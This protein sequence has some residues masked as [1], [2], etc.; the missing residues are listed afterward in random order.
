MPRDKTKKLGVVLLVVFLLSGLL[1]PL[2]AAAQGSTVTMTA[3]PYLGGHVKYGEW[4]ALRVTLHNDGG[5]LAA[6]VRAEVEGSTG[7]VLYAVPVQLPAGARKEVTVYV[8]PSSFARS[9]KVRLLDGD[10]VLAESSVPISTYPQRDYLIGAVA[11]DAGALVLLKGLT[12]SARDRTVLVPLALADLPERAEAL[13]SLDCLLLSGVDTTGMT[14]AQGKALDTWLRAGGRLLLGGGAGAD[15]TLAGLPESLQVQPG[16]IEELPLLDALAAFAGEPIR[17]P[18]PFVAAW[19]A[20]FGGRA[21]IRQGEQPLLVQRAVGEGW[22]SYLAL[23]PA[24]SP[25]DAWAGVLPFWQ[26]LLE[27]GSALPTN[28]PVDIPLRAIEAEMMGYALQ[29]VPAVQPPSIIWLAVLLGAYIVLVG[30]VN[31]FLLRRLRRLAWAWVTIPLLTLVFS[32]GGIA[33]G[34]QMRGNDVLISQISILPVSRGGGPI[35][36]RSY[37]GV[38]S[39]TSGRYNLR[40]D[41]EALVSPIGLDPWMWSGP[42]PAVYSPLYVLEGSPTRVGGLDIS[43][44]AMRSFQAE[45]VVNVEAFGFEVDLDSVGDQAR[46]TLRNGLDR[47]LEDVLL[48]SGARYARLGDLDPGEERAFEVDLQRFEGYYPGVLWDQSFDAQTMPSARSMRRTAVLEA[49]FQRYETVTTGLFVLA[50]T[51]L[52]PVSVHID[53]VRETHEQTTL[54]ISRPALPVVDGRVNLPLGYLSAQMTESAGDTGFCGP[55]QFYVGRGQITLDYLLP[56]D[57]GDLV[58]ESMTVQVTSA[59]GFPLEIPAVRLYDW[60]RAE[61]VELTGLKVAT[62]YQI[63]DPR[64]YVDGAGGM[65]RL[66][67]EGEREGFCFRFELSLGGRLEEGP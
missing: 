10:V 12:L 33:L 43:Q 17:V 42:S 54:L 23:D 56:A 48:F 6:E 3:A 67:A 24:G 1:L 35:L 9:I 25:F 7:Q 66:Q 47:P 40:L 49:L 15:R 8:L 22:L 58:V 41:G 45:T 29:N 27:P 20:E 39:P 62:P 36:A 44:W 38:F 26:R 14:A 32:V 60:T 5:D 57:L 55:T 4:L 52:D 13:R 59:D 30:P 21:L 65:I 2:R 37:V 31:Y 18:G 53:G 61:W 19:P 64:R 51:D 50:W 34:Y 46:G 11:G 28:A 63:A 16:D